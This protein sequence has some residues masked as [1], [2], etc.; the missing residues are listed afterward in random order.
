[1]LGDITLAEPDALI[2]FAGPRV[3]EDT[4]RESL[5]DGFQKSEYL[6]EHGMIDIVVSRTEIRDRLVNLLGLLLDR[7]PTA[8]IANMNAGNIDIPEVLAADSDSSGESEPLNR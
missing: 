8:E 2:G 1:M 6:F 4:I 3:I 7:Q 5:P